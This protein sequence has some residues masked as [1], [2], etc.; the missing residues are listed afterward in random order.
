MDNKMGG[1]DAVAYWKAVARFLAAY[2]AWSPECSYG[3]LFYA[4]VRARKAARKA[5]RKPAK[6]RAKP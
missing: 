3:P 1:V 5:A 2:D 4:M 6:A